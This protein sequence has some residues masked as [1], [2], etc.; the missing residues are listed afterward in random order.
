MRAGRGFTLVEVLV[1]I[2]V[3]GVLIGIALPALSSARRRAQTTLCLSNQRQ[4][5]AAINADAAANG[6]RLPENRVR[7]GPRDE[8]ITWRERFVRDGLIPSGEPWVCPLHPGEPLSELG[9]PDNTTVCVGDVES[10]YALN[11][12]LLWRFEVVGRDAVEPDTRIRRP[13][14]TIL[15]A[16]T[17]AP[18]PD[19]RATDNLI[20]T[21]LDD[22][23]LFGF[24]HDGR[25]AYAFQD[26]HAETIGLWS[27]G[28]PD[29]RWH[30]GPDL[31]EDMFDLQQQDEQRPHAHPDWEYLIHDVY[32]MR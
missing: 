20:A 21:D 30:N 5:I 15:L 3:V 8:H 29:C 27:T 10:S 32:G 13:S 2:A 18:Y 17:R 26:G 9:Q 23:G 19:L 4:I 22:G 7:L 31:D 11:G 1:V 14:H 12:H 25:G 16:E 24:W 6:G 28:N